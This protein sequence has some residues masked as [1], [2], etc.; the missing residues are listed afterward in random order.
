MKDLGPRRARST[1][2]E[3][4][5]RGFAL[6]GARNWTTYLTDLRGALAGGAAGWC[7]HNGDQRLR[8]GGPPSP[9]VRPPR[10]HGLFE[11]LD[12]VEA[13]AAEQLPTLTDP[14]GHAQEPKPAGEFQPTPIPESTPGDPR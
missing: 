10:P 12:P 4:F 11:G 6:L 8:P 7:L 3:P 1:D 13:R 9:L 5:R 2:Q 14:R